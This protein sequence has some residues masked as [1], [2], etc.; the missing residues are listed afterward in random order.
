V[1][2]HPL[3]VSSRPFRWLLA[4]FLIAAPP[5]AGA[6][7]GLL[8]VSSFPSGAEVLVDGVSTGRE[9]P[10]LLLLS[11]GAHDVAV[12]RVGSDWEPQ[13][14][15]I[16]ITRG[17]N[18]L[19]V[20]LVPVLTE[21]ATCWDLNANH[22]CE[23]GTEDATGDGLCTPADCRGPQGSPGLPG[24]PGAPGRDGSSC[25]AVRESD[26]ASIECEDGSS[27][28]VFDGAPGPPGPSASS[29]AG[30][31][32]LL[33]LD[34]PSISIPPEAIQP[35]DCGSAT[36]ALTLGG[37]ALGD[38]VGLVGDEGISRLFRYTIAIRMDDA[39]LDLEGLVG[40]A[41]R[42]FVRA[43]A[44]GGALDVSGIVTEIGLAAI[45]GDGALYVVVLEPSLARLS[46][47]RGYASFSDVSV[48]DVV[49][50]VLNGDGIDVSFALG[51]SHP[52]LPFDMQ[53]GETDLDFVS[54]LM[55]DEGMYFT[56][57]EDGTVVV[58]DDGASFTNGP[59][60]PYLGHFVPPSPALAALSSFRAS[61]GLVT[62][63]ATIAGF[64]PRVPAS[65]FGSA[66]AGSGLGEID[67]F[68]PDVTT[69]ARASLLARIELERARLEG[70]RHGGTSNAPDIRAGEVVGVTGAGDRFSG[71]YLV[72]GVTHALTP[73]DGAGACFSYGNA[74]TAIPA[75][76]AF[77]PPRRAPAPRVKGVLS[78]LVEDVDRDGYRVKVKFPWLHD[79]EGESSWMRVGH[80][81]GRG[82]ESFLPEVG[83]EVIVAFIA[84]DVSQPIVLGGLWNGSD[85]PPTR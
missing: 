20:T 52:P 14:R 40:G 83:D 57:A 39:G 49:E 19:D 43:R 1:P 66:S 11:T 17:R 5:F 62:A 31:A 74:F 28:R 47:S 36:L 42:L 60:L 13:T 71:Q 56:V 26:G 15:A 55:E 3:P 78:A 22:Q 12:R 32:Q 23:L 61:R 29:L 6:S 34:P 67:R 63:K 81:P 77:R 8:K 64:D 65:V 53:Y 37:A 44:S 80:P 75:G 33:G 59:S 30:L 76:Q 25:S 58:G 16:T 41:A 35:A 73:G 85:P 79:G 38:V 72:T 10:A 46:R 24:L 51:G 84:G 4:L 70:A 21:G 27:A 45:T 50:S 54:R 7:Q 18:D 9:T 82:D 69:S 2:S 68:L 48:P